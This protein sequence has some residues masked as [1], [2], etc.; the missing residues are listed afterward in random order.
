MRG[1]NVED[2]LADRP[3]RDRSTSS[4]EAVVPD[5][6]GNPKFSTDRRTSGACA[7]SSTASSRVALN[8]QARSRS[9]DCRMR[10]F[11]RT[12]ASRGSSFLSGFV[13]GETIQ[14]RRLQPLLRAA[15]A[16]P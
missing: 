5:S 1:S 8:S 16:Q 13:V 12:R 15:A 14:Q 3:G 9:T 11:D 7:R 4:D 2:R 6:A 10:R